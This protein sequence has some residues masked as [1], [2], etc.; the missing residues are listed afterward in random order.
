MTSV[1]R[2]SISFFAV[3]ASFGGAI[4]ASSLSGEEDGEFLLKAVAAS[5][6][7][8]TDAQAAA[9]STRRAEIKQTS[10]SIADDHVRASQELA[11]L[12]KRKGMN[13]PGIDAT[14]AG[15][16][17]TSRSGAESDSARIAGLLQAHEDAVALFHQEAVRGMDPDVK[18]FAQI[19]LPILQRRL[20]VLR[21]LQD[22][23]AEMSLS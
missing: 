17:A 7:E 6:Q 10:R 19:T 13:V 18:R 4:H 21:S 1:T 12:A 5:R 9:Q 20:E 2:L 3:A 22:A 15:D 23:Y 14:A 11:D 16:A 8:A